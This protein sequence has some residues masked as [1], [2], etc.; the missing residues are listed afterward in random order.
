MSR[1]VPL[2]GFLLLVALFGFGIWW[3]T[4]HNP[5]EVLS[6]LINRPAPE[7]ALPVLDDPTS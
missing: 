7:F 2:F 1:L 3:N 6:P 5:T 4:Q